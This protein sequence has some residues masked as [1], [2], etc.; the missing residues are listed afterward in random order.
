MRSFIQTMLLS[1]CSIH[2]TVCVCVCVCVLTHSASAVSLK[3]IFHPKTGAVFSFSIVKIKSLIPD[4]IQ[5]RL[6]LNLFPR[7]GTKREPEGSGEA[8]TK[9]NDRKLQRK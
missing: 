5:F 4:L 2:V 8:G 9:Q 3:G 1:S 6:H 7:E